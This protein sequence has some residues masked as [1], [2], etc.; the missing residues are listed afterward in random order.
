MEPKTNNLEQEKILTGAHNRAD[1]VCA[2]DTAIRILLIEQAHEE[3][4]IIG[5]L[6]S[7]VMHTDYQLTWCDQ[8]DDALEEVLSD[9]YDVVLLDYYCGDYRGCDLLRAAQAQGCKIPIVVM[10]DEMETD[11]DR[12]VISAGASDYLVKGRIDSQLLER[13]IRYAIERKTA[14]MKLARLAHYD[15]LTNIPNRILFRDRLE[16]AVHL[17]DRDQLHFALMYLDL[18]GFKD[19]NDTFGHDIGDELICA[20][21]DRLRACMR[22]SDAVARIGGDEFTLLLEH[23]DNSTHIAHIAEKI[24][25]VVTR[26]YQIGRHQVQIGCSIGIAV[27]PDISADAQSLQ[28]YADM[29][30]YEAK[31]EE[32]N[33]YRFFTDAM[34]REAR[35]QL[36]LEAELRRA[37]RRNEFC[38]YYQ[39]RIDLFSG[40]IIGLEAL[41]R[42]SH[43]ER[44][45]VP[46]ADF[47]SAAESTGLIAP[48][49]YWV[50]HRACL[51]LQRLHQQ[52]LPP[53][54]MAV[55]L[56]LRQFRDDKLVER[57]ATVLRETGVRGEELELEITESAIVENVD[58]ISLCMRALSHLG[59][60]F[61]VDDFG[62]GY[63]SFMHLQQLP[64]G[65]MKIDRRLIAQATVS[66]SGAAL[67]NAMINLAHN[68]DKQIV[69]EGVETRAQLQLLR[70]L[71]CD[72]AQGY[73][74]GR[75]ASFSEICRQLACAPVASV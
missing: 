4:L 5:R 42:W 64:I 16:H 23:T 67:V 36:L 72:Q 37:L 10:T 60:S 73:L 35:R 27:Y 19:V 57:V 18:D 58:L 2:T 52:G 49:G 21:A 62:T 31:Q 55:N 43:P 61:S 47:M 25:E 9:C 6:L 32:G 53:V 20:F 11:V 12:Q 30:M 63:S 66:E 74:L 3:F 17:A 34:N 41:V 13:T 44:G 29:A 28:K 68:L 8:L 39:P 56:S 51:D 15:P 65:T 33:S 70:H 50:L 26:P 75:P 54:R 48:L 1:A 7:E 59:V 24:L 46:P 22:S 71:K 69:A 40:D 45:F 38:L 14:E